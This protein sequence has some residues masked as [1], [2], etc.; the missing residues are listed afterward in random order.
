MPSE[1][2]GDNSRDCKAGEEFI[3]AGLKVQGS[4]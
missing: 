1:A 3:G 2:G 4:E